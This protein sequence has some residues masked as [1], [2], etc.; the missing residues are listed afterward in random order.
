M[1]K[2]R[3]YIRMCHQA[4]LQLIM[5]LDKL[6]GVFVFISREILLIPYPHS[7]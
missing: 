2:C 7:D 3:D 5:D 6:L 4:R 1:L